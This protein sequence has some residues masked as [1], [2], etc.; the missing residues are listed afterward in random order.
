[1]NTPAVP[2]LSDAVERAQERLHTIATLPAQTD[3]CY[4]EFLTDTVFDLAI[5]PVKQQLADVPDPDDP[6]EVPI[7]MRRIIMMTAFHFH[8]TVGQVE[9]DLADAIKAFPTADIRESTALQ[10]R[11]LLH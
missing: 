9:S 3:Q 8:R 10:H 7:A 4:R 6:A 11:G 1:M 5:I 2:R